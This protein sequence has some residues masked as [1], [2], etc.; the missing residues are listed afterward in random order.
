MAKMEQLPGHRPKYGRRKSLA[1]YPADYD[2]I[3]NF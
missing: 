2:L 3:P 1:L